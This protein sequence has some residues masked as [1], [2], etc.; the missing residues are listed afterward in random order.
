M[1][2]LSMIPF[3]V[4]IAVSKMPLMRSVYYCFDKTLLRFPFTLTFTPIYLSI[5][6]YLCLEDIMVSPS[7]LRLPRINTLMWN[8]TN[9]ADWARNYL[10]DLFI[11]DLFYKCNQTKV[12]KS[13][14]Q[15]PNAILNPQ[16]KSSVSTCWMCWWLEEYFWR[17]R[18]KRALS[19]NWRE[20]PGNG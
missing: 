11:T 5:L 16:P 15:T 7:S 20:E 18:K 6:T 2:G 9:E 4:R 14:H 10:R 19:V 3:F 1:R 17:R 13:Y 12:D 8:L